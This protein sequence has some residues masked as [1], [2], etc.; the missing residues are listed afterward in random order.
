M[1]RRKKLKANITEAIETLTMEDMQARLLQAPQDNR[2]AEKTHKE[3]RVDLTLHA[4]K[5][6]AKW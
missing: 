2:Q 5:S 4:L 3:S 6:N 1:W